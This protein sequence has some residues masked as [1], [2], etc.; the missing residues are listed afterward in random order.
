M[1]RDLAAR[2][3][4]L[5][6]DDP[7]YDTPSMPFDELKASRATGD[8]QT[9]KGID[10]TPKTIVDITSLTPVPPDRVIAETHVPGVGDSLAV[11]QHSHRLHALGVHSL[12]VEQRLERIENMLAQKLNIDHADDQDTEPAPE[13]VVFKNDHPPAD[14]NAGHLNCEARFIRLEKQLA[15]VLGNAGSRAQK[16]EYGAGRD[17]DGDASTHGR[18]PHFYDSHD[19]KE[20]EHKPKND[21]WYS[22]AAKVLQRRRA[23]MARHRDGRE[24]KDPSMESIF[25]LDPHDDLDD[26]DLEAVERMLGDECQIM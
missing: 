21:H 25:D 1:T 7:L 4:R 24:G 9:E 19:R 5:E 20:T 2:D 22:K 15:H 11:D 23:D 6:V 17:F 14:P 10:C 26:S 13:S 18:N 16:A 8:S 3:R 12:T